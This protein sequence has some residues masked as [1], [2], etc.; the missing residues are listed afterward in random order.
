MAESDKGATPKVNTAIPQAHDRVAVLSVRADGTH[1]QLNP[2]L[3]DADAAREYTKRQFAEQAVGASDD[4]NAVGP[5]TIIGKPGDEP[6]EV[7][8]ATSDAVRQDPSI[9]ERQA[10]HEK[11]AKAAERAAEAVVNELAPKKA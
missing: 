6:D 5:V 3:L 2:E 8:P 10:E 7:V 9:A 4:A 11:I 1:D